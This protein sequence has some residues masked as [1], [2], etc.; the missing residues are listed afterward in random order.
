MEVTD[1]GT[2]KGGVFTHKKK[3]EATLKT[4]TL[5]LILIIKK[6]HTNNEKEKKHMFLGTLDLSIYT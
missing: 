1:E 2:F 3:K 5:S 4:H 6:L